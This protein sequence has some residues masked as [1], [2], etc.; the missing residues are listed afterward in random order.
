M[1][2]TERWPCPAKDWC[3]LRRFSLGGTPNDFCSEGDYNN[4]ANLNRHIKLQHEG[5][6]IPPQK[7]EYSLSS[8]WRPIIEANL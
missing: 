5:Q 1:E 8:F 7:R 2:N 4:I 3:V 6:G